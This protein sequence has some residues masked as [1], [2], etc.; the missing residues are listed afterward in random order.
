MHPTRGLFQNSRLYKSVPFR[1]T[2]RCETPREE[3]LATIVDCNWRGVTQNE[4]GGAM[5]LRAHGRVWSLPTLVCRQAQYT[6]EPKH[7]L[8]TNDGVIWEI[9]SASRTDDGLFWTCIATKLRM[10]RP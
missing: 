4:S 2:L 7:L 3:P 5:E 8:R 10:H 6:P 1:E 9:H